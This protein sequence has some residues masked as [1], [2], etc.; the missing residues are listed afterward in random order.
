MTRRLFTALPLMTVLAITGCG[1][2]KET[3]ATPP[4]PAKTASAP[5]G[6]TPPPPKNAVL[7]PAGTVN[8]AKQS[9]DAASAK[10]SAATAEV[11]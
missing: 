2:K 3:A 5:T 8:W 6:T 1:K 11:R 9:L 10:E 4:A 7:N